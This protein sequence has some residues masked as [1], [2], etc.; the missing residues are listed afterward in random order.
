MKISLQIELPNLPAIANKIAKA[1]A[2]PHTAE[3]TASNLTY[4]V[5]ITLI[6]QL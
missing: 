6:S 3:G 4:L 1:I 2:V 5:C